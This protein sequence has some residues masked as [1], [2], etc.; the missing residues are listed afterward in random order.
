MNYYVDLEICKLTG[1]NRSRDKEKVQ[2][3]KTEAFSQIRPLLS[4]Y[5]LYIRVREQLI[6]PWLL[7]SVLQN[8]HIHKYQSNV[9]NTLVLHLSGKMQ[10]FKVFGCCCCCL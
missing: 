9:Q 2:C 1:C 6:C 4:T 5:N 3:G 7:L 10:V 8:K